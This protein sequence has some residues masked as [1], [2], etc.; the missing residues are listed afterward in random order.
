MFIF[1]EVNCLTDEGIAQ[2]EKFYKNHN[3]SRLR[4]VLYPRFPAFVQA[5]T[6][7]GANEFKDVYD[8]TIL[9][10]KSPGL[11][12]GGDHKFIKSPK[13]YEFVF[14]QLSSTP[15]QIDVHIKK[16]SLQAINSSK[17]NLEKWI[18]KTWYNKE[19]MIENYV[20]QHVSPNTSLGIMARSNEKVKHQWERK[21]K[22]WFNFKKGKAQDEEEDV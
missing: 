7:L 16:T 18:E 6:T 12:G 20:E 4:Q 14:G 17:Q 11:R 3:L 5:C 2:H 19:V 8:V 10:S 21:T 13:L 9:Y 22:K 1:P 15:W